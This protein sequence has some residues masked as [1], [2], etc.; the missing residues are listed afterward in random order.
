MDLFMFIGYSVL[1]YSF[2]K[3]ASPHHILIPIFHAPSC[4]YP[5]SIPIEPLISHNLTTSFHLSIPPSSTSLTIFLSPHHLSFIPYLFSS[6]SCVHDVQSAWPPSF[7]LHPHTHNLIYNHTHHAQDA[8]P[9]ALLLISHSCIGTMHAW[10]SSLLLYPLPSTHSSNSHTTLQ[11][12]IFQ[13]PLIHF[14]HYPLITFSSVATPLCTCDD[15]PY[16][17]LDFG[18]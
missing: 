18:R 2:L 7:S 1:I 5:F 6:I 3:K 17:L 14:Y 4:I 15:R 8:L 16:H 13:Y 12:I 10:P 11:T 9:A